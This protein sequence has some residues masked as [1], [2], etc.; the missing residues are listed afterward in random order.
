MEIKNTS[1]YKQ[2]NNPGNNGEK[3]ALINSEG[4]DFFKFLLSASDKDMKKLELRLTQLA[5]M[6]CKAG[7]AMEKEME[8]RR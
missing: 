5:R 4:V 7:K 1:R 2:I 6:T 8:M 3:S